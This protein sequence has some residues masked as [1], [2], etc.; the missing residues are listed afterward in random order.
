M[1]EE[2]QPVLQPQNHA[3]QQ[4][5]LPN[6]TTVLIL[7]ILSVITCCCYGITSIIFSI[8]AL[9]MA[10]KDLALYNA[11]PE[12]YSNYDHLKIGRIL[13]FV[14]LGFGALYMLYMIVVF[15]FYGSLAM[16]DPSSF[17]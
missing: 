10:N 13:A 15:V 12:L 3:K 6:A 17:M 1:N 2:E 9:I 5:K 8:I 4:Q 16:M 14:G 7:G 11:S